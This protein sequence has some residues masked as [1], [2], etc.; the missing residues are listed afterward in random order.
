M[1]RLAASRIPAPV[2]ARQVRP[3]R[4]PRIGRLALPGH[5]SQ[6]AA[7]ANKKH[8]LEKMPGLVQKRLADV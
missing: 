6:Q 2:I 8:G 4:L 1:L 7:L 5:V 3:L